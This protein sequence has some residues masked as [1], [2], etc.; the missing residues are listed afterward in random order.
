MKPSGLKFDLVPPFSSSALLQ[1]G[2]DHIGPATDGM[3]QHA[4]RSKVFRDRSCRVENITER[5]APRAEQSLYWPPFDSED[6]A[7]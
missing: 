5:E 2:S 4:Q 3:A 6:G 7:L 1:R